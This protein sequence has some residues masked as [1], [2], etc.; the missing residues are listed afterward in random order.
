LAQEIRRV[1]VQHSDDPELSVMNSNYKSEK[2]DY[3][4][5]KANSDTGTT[6][7]AVTSVI[8]KQLSFRFLPR[9]FQIFDFHHARDVIGNALN[10][11]TSE[12][13]NLEDVQVRST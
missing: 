9:S 8:N 11:A 6:T 7:T 3:S 2:S 10:F 4:D 12:L 1:Y 5:D 13:W